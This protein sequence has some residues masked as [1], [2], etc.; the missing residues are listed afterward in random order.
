MIVGNWWQWEEKAAVEETDF[1]EEKPMDNNI[2]LKIFM[3]SQNKIVEMELEEYVEGVVSAEMPATFHQEALKAQA[4][5]A[6]TYAIYKSFAFGSC[7]CQKHP[8]ADICT[9][10]QCCQAWIDNKE[11]LD[12]WAVPE[13]AHY[14]EVIRKAVR[15]TRGQIATYEGNP[16]SAVYHSTCGGRTET[17]SEVWNSSSTAHPSLQG[18]ECTYCQHSPY[19]KTDLVLGF[20]DYT[21]A[22][23]KG[24]EVLPVLAEGNT[25][26]LEAVKLSAGGRN[27]LLKI[28]NPGPFYSGNEVRDLLG[29]PSTWFHW[30]IEGEKIIFS[31]R[32]HGHGVG[33]CQYGAD[34]LAK[35][36]KGYVEIL[37]HY[38]QGVEI[39][40]YVFSAGGQ[41]ENAPTEGSQAAHHPAVTP[42]YVVDTPYL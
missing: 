33:M 18:V 26:L 2:V 15:S 29:L 34:G 6:R 36:G 13:G 21:A 28:G 30:R 19:Y 32:G 40:D 37:K 1:W 14:Q 31:V 20:P 3:E 16:I 24:K 41:D 7:G 17:A 23:N 25:P 42:A 8:G 9:D 10:S 27:L 38:Y 11:A 5:A 4:V 12:K 35:E 22:L 39:E